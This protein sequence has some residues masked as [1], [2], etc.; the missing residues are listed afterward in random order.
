MK[1]KKASGARAEVPPSPVRH[2]TVVAH[3]PSIRG[4]DGR[5]LTAKIAVPAEAL[6]AGPIGY[7]V[8][9]VDYDA[10]TRR[11]HGSHALPE[12][13]ADEPPAWR[14]GDESILR[15]PRFHAQNAYALV[16]K[17]LARF[18]Q[19]LGRRLGWSF[20]TH[21]IKIAPHGMNDAN[22]FY[23]PDEEGLIFGYFTGV[24][25]DPVY[26]CLSHD[27][28][29]HEATHALID[30]LRSRYMDSSNPDQAAFHEGFADV[31]ALL[32]V[33]SQPEVVEHLLGHGKRADGL[34]AREKVTAQALCESALFGLADEMGAEIE[35]LRGN[36]LRRSAE[37]TPSPHHRY[38]REF[39]E[40]HRRGEL[41]VAAVLRGFINVWA[42]R[43]AHSGPPGLKQYPLS[44]VVEEAASI[45]DLLITLWIRALD[46]MP[47]VHL[48]F[49][50]ALSAALTA[51][52][53]VR[54]D[55]SRYELRRHMI[56][57]FKK[58]GF[59]PSSPRKDPF[60]VW[61]PPAAH[62]SYDHVRFESM[63]SDPDEVFRFIWD[64]R[65]E[66]ELREGAY[67]EVLSVRPSRRTG[68]DGFVLRETVVEY[69][70][71]ARLTPAEL[72][73]K[74]IK[75]PPDYLASLRERAR[76]AAAGDT[77]AERSVDGEQPGSAAEE[78]MVT[79]LYGGAVLI[80]DE[81]G[82]VKY[83]IWN[84]VFG[85]KKQAE[86]LAYL[87]NEG[88]L[89]ARRR[90]ARPRGATLSTLHRLRATDARKFPVEAW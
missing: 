52:H 48:E 32:S 86:R 74:G 43:I 63:R 72:R 56:A 22:A 3:D 65:E 78:D 40:P 62:L 17:T 16:M 42:D 36:A 54:P 31:I 4:R 11:F 57:E 59:E 39:L 79:P 6:A 85:K 34:I 67:T 87:W 30:S 13:Y 25:G 73:E 23:S 64:N 71:V 8:Q 70:Q 80:F 49:G 24:S 33:F 53:E 19:A 28:I 9:V 37:I 45:A 10:T 35:G 5:I 12:S 55:D 18:E 27:I 61:S 38:T 21:Q 7:R 81:Y 15:D 2:M 51:D 44:R 50:D 58:F 84:D 89:V 41:F 46:Y 68:S 26:T 77:G 75:A 76:A 20:G 88:F 90:G 29:V 1:R 47:P 60:G 69:Y 66:L 14:R 82:Q 83:R